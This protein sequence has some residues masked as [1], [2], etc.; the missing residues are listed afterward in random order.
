MHYVSPFRS[1]LVACF[2]NRPF[3][4]SGHMVR[5]KLHWDASYA[6]GLSKQRNSD[7]SS[8]TFLCFESPIV[9]L[10]SQCYLFC[11][12][13]SDPAKAFSLFIRLS[14]NLICHLFQTFNSYFGDSWWNGLFGH[15]FEWNNHRSSRL[16]HG[17]CLYPGLPFYFTKFSAEDVQD[18]DVCLRRNHVYCCHWR[19]CSNF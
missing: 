5:N 9:Q 4:G 10:A 17:C 6:V 7:Q 12:M 11:T 8:P 2:T 16:P 15:K 19:G 18:I 14:N 1:V 13:W 3:A